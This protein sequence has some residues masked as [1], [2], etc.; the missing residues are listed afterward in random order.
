MEHA[1]GKET[2]LGVNDD[3]SVDEEGD[4]EEITQY[5]SAI[6]KLMWL[7]VC[8]RPDITTAVSRLSRALQKPSWKHWTAVKKLLRYLQHTKTHGLVYGAKD[9][10]PDLYLHGWVDS[11]WGGFQGVGRKATTGW[12]FLLNGAAISWCSKLQTTVSLSTTEAEYK[13]LASSTQEAVYLRAILMDLGHMQEGAT[14]IGEDNSGCIQLVHNPVFHARSNHIE[15]KYHFSREKVESGEINVV[16]EHTEDMVADM[17]TKILNKLKL[18]Q[19]RSSAGILS[20]NVKE[21]A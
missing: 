16:K 5:R 9:Y 6:G 20:L 15:T 19:H 21:S 7:S 3:L 11:D 10:C 13:A 4:F 12:I 2:T 17:L 1:K 18:E 14:T 8:T